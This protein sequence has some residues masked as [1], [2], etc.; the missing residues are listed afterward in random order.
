M[1]KLLI[2]ILFSFITGTSFAQKTDSSK[3]KAGQKKEDSVTKKKNNSDTGQQRKNAEDTNQKIS[4]P[5][6]AQQ[7]DSVSRAQLIKAK[8]QTVKAVKKDSSQLA[9]VHPIK[10]TIQAAI[11]IRSSRLKQD[12][13]LL[14]QKILQSHPYFNF[15]D[16]ATFPPYTKKINPPGKEIYFYGIAALL[17]I[18]A[19]L[20]AGFEKYFSDLMHLFFRRSLKQRQLKQQVI[21]NSLPSLL[22]NLFFIII[23]GFYAALVINTFLPYPE[24]T[25]WE[26]FAGSIIV[27][28]CIYV[29][30]YFI[31]KFI[32]WAFRIT[33]LTDNYIFL[34]FLV[35]KI[36]ALVLLPLIVIIALSNKQLS[37]VA[38]TLSWV[39]I[40]GVMIYRY[41]SA[42]SLVR[43]E[44]SIGFFHFLLY[45]C[46]FEVL[47]TIVLYKG[48]L[49]I[50]K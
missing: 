19:I 33:K 29:S 15:K 30:K 17:I 38:W 39:F 25:F 26:L 4:R 2:I 35:N 41:I 22:F 16:A 18:F 34:I 48:I 13:F 11:A 45:V 28:S 32:G 9:S 5:K 24:F 31:L 44:N 1:G 3:E 21:Q 27:I 36:I 14:T 7:P 40:T 43:K 8:P 6:P 10:D 42:A 12:D 23:A 20:K 47:P 50:L 49:S 37:T 46:A